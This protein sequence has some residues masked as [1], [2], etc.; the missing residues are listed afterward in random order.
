MQSAL[1]AHVAL[2]AVAP[3]TYGA[4]GVSAVTHVPMP[5]H[6]STLALPPVQAG[7]AQDVVLEYSV[8]EP[9]PLQEPVVPH[10]DAAWVPHSLSGSPELGAVGRIGA[11]TPFLPDVP[12]LASEHAMHPPLHAVSQQKPSTQYPD[13]HCAFKVQA[14]PGA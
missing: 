14:E 2:H 10:V 4:H 12:F 1:D 11:H 3:H 9:L 8:H 13:G 7:D 6:V 5:L